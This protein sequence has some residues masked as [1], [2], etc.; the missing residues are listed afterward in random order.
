MGLSKSCIPRSEI[1]KIKK[2]RWKEE[3]EVVKNGDKINSD[4]NNNVDSDRGKN[5]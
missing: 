4:Q 3:V 5:A 1:K 2:K